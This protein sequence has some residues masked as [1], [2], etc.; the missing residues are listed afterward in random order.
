MFI[1]KGNSYKH[2]FIKLHPSDETHTNLKSYINPGISKNKHYF[3]SNNIL[4]E[5]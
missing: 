2:E 5:L 4:N 3:V 1:D